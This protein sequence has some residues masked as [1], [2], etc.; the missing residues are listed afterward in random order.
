MWRLI[1]HVVQN[2]EEA[3]EIV[4]KYESMIGRKGRYANAIHTWTMRG[5]IVGV[6]AT[7]YGAHSSPEGENDG[8]VECSNLIEV[9]FYVR[10]LNKPFDGSKDTGHMVNAATIYVK[11]GKPTEVTW[12][13]TEKG[14]QEC[15]QDN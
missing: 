1:E 15:S 2:D 14:R 9:F 5:E 3:E 10:E 11:D 13:L 6:E 8:F 12:A 7:P 4:R